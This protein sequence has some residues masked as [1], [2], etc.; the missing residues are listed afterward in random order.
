V[1]VKRIEF[2]FVEN[3]VLGELCVEPLECIEILPLVSVIECLAEIEVL[4]VAA[5]SRTDSK[6]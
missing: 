5:G 3:V 1:I 6:S 2:R 4:H